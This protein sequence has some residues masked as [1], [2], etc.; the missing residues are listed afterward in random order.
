MSGSAKKS[1]QQNKRTPSTIFMICKAIEAIKS[2]R[3]GCSRQAIASY[4]L[5]NYD[6]ESGGRFNAT[7][8]NALKKGLESGILKQGETLQRFKLGPAA[9]SITNPPKPKKKA[10]AKA[11]AKKKVAKKDKKVGSKKKKSTTNKKKATTS[12]KKKSTT[13]KKNGSRKKTATKKKSAG[14]KKKSTG[15]KNKRAANKEKK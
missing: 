1:K 8:R 4:I 6:K 7:L 10:K 3:K 5:E 15:N 13:A 14:S 12:K 11:N 9:K 2:G